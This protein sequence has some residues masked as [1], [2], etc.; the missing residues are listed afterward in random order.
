MRVGGCVF[1]ARSL[2]NVSAAPQ[3]ECAKPL[4]R[5]IGARCAHDRGDRAVLH[6]CDIAAHLRPEPH[7]ILC[8][9][10]RFY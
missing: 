5:S 6:A 1:L 8:A 7:T 9:L 2:R 3:C 10:T 4:S